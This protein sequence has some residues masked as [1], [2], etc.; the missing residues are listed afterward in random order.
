[1]IL[2][3]YLATDVP[4]GYTGI[5]LDTFEKVGWRDWDE[6]VACQET[7]GNIKRLDMLDLGVRCSEKWGIVGYLESREMQS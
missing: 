4:F 5:E 7:V 6:R 2:N 1:M 3:I